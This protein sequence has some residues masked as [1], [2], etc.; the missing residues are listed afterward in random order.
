MGM[1]RGSREGGATLSTPQGEIRPL[2]PPPLQPRH[3]SDKPLHPAAAVRS[4]LIPRR[5]LHHLFLLLLL[6]PCVTHAVTGNL[7]S[8]L[9]CVRLGRFPTLN[10][11]P[12]RSL[13]RLG[14]LEEERETPF[15]AHLL[16]CILFVYILPL[17]VS[18]VRE[19]VCERACERACIVWREAER[20]RVEARILC[21]GWR[22]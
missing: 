4:W 16:L 18:S 5:R 21:A 10:W 14:L 1:D 9:L 11:S 22:F 2:S 7:E 15:L 17:S 8:P 19:C 6:L 3:H 12:A 13:S 20:S